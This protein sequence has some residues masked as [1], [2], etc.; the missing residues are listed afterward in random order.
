MQHCVRI[1]AA[2]V[3]DRVFA[4]LRSVTWAPATPRRPRPA[5]RLAAG[6]RDPIGLRRIAR[7]AEAVNI[8]LPQRGQ[9]TERRGDVA[10]HT[11]D[12]PNSM[13]LPWVRSIAPSG[14]WA[15]KGAQQIWPL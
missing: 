2:H 8:R 11:V 1:E 15:T 4:T 3:R 7:Q 10:I 6:P 12:A 13:Y 14:R 9:G 5:I